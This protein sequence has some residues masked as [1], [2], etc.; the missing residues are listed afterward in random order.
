M[1]ISILPN[2]QAVL[3]REKI[4]FTIIFQKSRTMKKLV[5]FAVSFLYSLP[6][7][8]AQCTYP[9]PVPPAGDLCIEAPLLCDYGLNGYCGTL[10]APTGSEYPFPGCGSS[11]VTNAHYLKFVA[12]SEFLEIAILPGSCQGSPNMTGLQAGLFRDCIDQ[13]ASSMVASPIAVSCGANLDQFTL[14]AIVEI[15]QT[16]Y[17]ML[18][19]F[20]SSIC[21]YEII[22]LEG[23]TT[24]PS[25]T[26]VNLSLAGPDYVQNNMTYSFSTDNLINVGNYNWTVTGGDI[27]TGAGT[28][29][30]TVEVTNDFNFEVCVEGV[31]DCSQTETTCQSFEINPELIIIETTLCDGEC[32]ELNETFY[33]ETGVYNVDVDN[34]MD[35]S[36]YRIILT[37]NPFIETFVSEHVC[38]GTCYQFDNQNYC[39]SGVYTAVFTSS[40]GCD[41]MVTLELTVLDIDEPMVEA[42]NSGDLD[43]QNPTTTLMASSPFSGVSYLWTGPD[44]NSNNEN[45]QSPQVGLSGLYTVVVSTSSGCTSSASTEVFGDAGPPDITITGNDPFNCN[46]DENTIVVTGANNG[47]E[48]EWSGPGGFVETGHEVTVNETGIYTLIV[49]TPFGCIDTVI[50]DVTE[51]SEPLF[52]DPGPSRHIQCEFIITID[53]PG[54]VGTN[55]VYE[56]TT[57]NGN[58]LFGEN[59]LNP[60]VNI[61]GTYTLTAT[62]LD[63]GC[64]GT[65]D[66]VV[67]SELAIVQDQFVELTCDI[68]SLVLDGSESY[69]GQD[70]YIQW[71]TA[72]GNI[73]S[74]QNTLTPT[75][76]APGLYQLTIFK[77]G[78]VS[79]VMVTVLDNTQAPGV[80][81]DASN[82]DIT[83][84]Q[85]VTLTGNTNAPNGQYIW[86]KNNVQFS[87]DQTIIVTEPATYTFEVTGSNGCTGTA[88]IDIGLDTDPSAILISG[89]LILDCSLNGVGSLE[90]EISGNS[91]F[92]NTIWTPLNGGEILGTNNTTQV[93][94][95]GPGTYCVEVTNP[96]N[97]CMLSECIDVIEISPLELNPTVTDVSCPN[98]FDGSIE[99]SVTGGTLPY[100]YDWSTGQFNE[101]EIYNLGPDDYSVT[102]TDANGC[103]SFQTFT[104]EVIGNEDITADAGD[105]QFLDCL[106]SILVLDGG[107]SVFPPGTTFYWETNNGTIDD[108]ETT[109]FPT[110]SSTGTYV[111]TIVSPEGC[112]DTDEVVIEEYLA[113]A[114]PIL[115]IDCNNPSLELQGSNGQSG[116]SYEW[117]T[118]NGNIVNNGNTLNPTVDA[119]GDYT[120]IVTDANGCTY[121]DETSVNGDFDAPDVSVVNAVLYLEDCISPVLLQGNSSTQG[122]T[123]FW[124]GPAGMTSNNANFSVDLEG[125]Y[126][127]TVTGPNG[128][129]N[130]ES[131]EVID[132]AVRPELVG[133]PPTQYINCFNGNPLLVAIDVQSESGQ[134]E[135][136][137]TT[138]TGNIVEE[139]N[140][141]IVVDQAGVY[142]GEISDP[143]NG[144]VNQSSIVVEEQEAE[145]EVETTIASCGVP[146]ATATVNTTYIHNPKYQWS[147][148]ES[149]ASIGGLAPGIYTVTITSPTSTC[150]EVQTIE[151]IQDPSCFVIVS[152]Y[153]Y[154]DPTLSCDENGSVEPKE[155]VL[156]NITP[157]D[158]ETTT[159]EDGYYEFLVPPGDYTVTPDLVSPFVVQCPSESIM[160]SVDPGSSGSENNNFFVKALS[161]FDLYVTAGS[162]GANAGTNQY[163]QISFCN[164]A[165]TT[166]FGTVEFTHDPLLEFD[167]VVAGASSYD[168]T[169]YTAVWEFED[170]TFF[171]CEYFNFTVFVPGDIPD[172][173]IIHST[174]LVLP[175][176]GDISPQNNSTSW[177]RTVRN[178][179]NSS[180][181]G[182]EED[183]IEINRVTGLF[184]EEVISVV[185]QYPNP[186]TD[187]TTIEFELQTEVEIELSIFDARGRL[188]KTYTDFEK[189]FN[190]LQIQGDDLTKGVYFYKIVGPSLFASGRMIKN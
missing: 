145:I 6:F 62:N 158:L 170:L 108:G 58:I 175:T 72:N 47:L 79:F 153:I 187:E 115:T 126:L 106:T 156:V 64:V 28:N 63:N 136:E 46:N 116:A 183:I 9:D 80:S 23:E 137:W 39:N 77:P 76:D 97:G 130:S 22:V 128:C 49:T 113:E 122:A 12:G 118:N 32:Y 48:Y 25:L 20:A 112:T 82:M 189:G 7:L 68:T 181:I 148:G 16:Y 31:N 173:T 60:V 114:G 26:G 164:N 98:S 107:S 35:T 86:Y 18:N 186:F 135:V 89:D 44:I 83:C 109:L 179:T 40:E 21:D 111:L 33:C 42:S 138:S 70:A 162:G 169:T 168:S 59:T 184:D 27:L 11:A 54:A 155:G 95:L 29:E 174:V 93:E 141:S 73:V 146:D 17:L 178:T 38:F 160:V 24:V 74:G 69:N 66:M 154:F 143:V 139:I 125:L 2:I 167:P 102:V 101:S 133:T 131:V 3:Y 132:I 15:G 45:E 119:E 147:T 41:S 124:S 13:G 50:V 157:E 53:A 100:S 36:Y 182:Q 91:P 75:V 129:T 177:N 120:L 188:V 78:C 121:T 55:I 14:T 134:V 52:V 71:Y 5:L 176:Q 8:T 30:V 163:Y 65:A 81:I 92:Y 37:V 159:D 87:N 190:Q 10:P 172:G 149:T 104:I 96:N 94:I 127:L 51:N 19:G 152:G 57:I 140:N 85:A 151:I 105:D 144:C 34:G 110:V 84:S 117:T 103:L 142:N 90:V 61:A 43:C 161:G 1:A 88:S 165:F 56:W 150:D 185:K 166:I 123:F 99:L 67:Y 180:L 4:L 171:E